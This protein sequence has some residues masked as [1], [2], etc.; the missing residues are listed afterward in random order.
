MSI[1]FPKDTDC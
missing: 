1:E